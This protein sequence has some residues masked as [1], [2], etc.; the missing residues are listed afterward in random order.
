MHPH[1][2]K[3]SRQKVERTSPAHFRRRLLS[4]R[5]RRPSASSYSSP[6]G[7]RARA[8]PIPSISSSAPSKG[9]AGS[10]SSRLE[11]RSEERRV[12]KEGRSGWAAERYEEKEYH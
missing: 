7:R 8:T 10:A 6:T 11:S 2:S 9:A 1:G 5:Q 3:V 4:L 12:G